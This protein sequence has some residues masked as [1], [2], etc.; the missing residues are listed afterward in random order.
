MKKFIFISII[1]GLSMTFLTAYRDTTVRPFNEV[2]AHF[3]EATRLHTQRDSTFGVQIKVPGMFQKEEEIS[4][5]AY[6]YARY[7]YYPPRRYTDAWGQITLI[8]S[9][10]VCR[11]EAKWTSRIDSITR[12]DG[13]TEYTKYIRKQ[14][15]K[16]TYQLIYPTVYDNSVTR[17]KHEVRSW[18]ALSTDYPH[19]QPYVLRSRRHVRMAQ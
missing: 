10:T 2:L 11:D 4:Q 5:V 8:Y 15:I 3:I 18:Q 17:L 16:F 6:S 14:K 19:V 13:Y 9:A 1:V 12:D 7:V